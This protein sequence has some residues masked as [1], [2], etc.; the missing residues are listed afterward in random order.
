MSE[1]QDYETLA[2]AVRRSARA[3]VLEIRR[4]LLAK[5]AEERRERA[6]MVPAD[7]VRA[8][9]IDVAEGTKEDMG[10]GVKALH[11]DPYLVDE[12]DDVAVKNAGMLDMIA[13]VADVVDPIGPAD[14]GFPLLEDKQV[15]EDMQVAERTDAG[16]ELLSS[17]AAG[18]VQPE[19]LSQEGAVESDADLGVQE[20][21]G[22]ET[23]PSKVSDLEKLPGAGPGLIWMLNQCGVM[24]LDDLAAKDPAELS[25][26]LGVVGLILDVERWIAIA[27][28][29]QAA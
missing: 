16:Y 26:K 19:N 9:V 10:S 21:E 17:V 5:R 3:H 2:V 13:P 18:D 12:R 7:E 4:A 20:V 28:A 25:P 6:E 8:A 15:A 1:Q 11:S 27:S 22:T 24:T 23:A 14:T 29:D